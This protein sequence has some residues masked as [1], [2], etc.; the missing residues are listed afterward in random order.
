MILKIF[1]F[2]RLGLF[3]LTYLGSRI[4]HL[5]PNSGIGSISPFQQFDYWKSMAQWDGGHYWNIATSGYSS[6]EDFAFFPL[7]PTLI[8][9]LSPLFLANTLLTG[10]L[11]SNIAFFLF[12][13]FFHKLVSAKYGKKIAFDA[14]V[15]FIFFPTTFFTVSYYSES[16]FLLLITL[17]FMY[18]QRKKFILTAFV[19]SLASLTR[20][21]GIFLAIAFLASYIS[22]LKFKLS[23]VNVNLFWLI[24]SLSGFLLYS[25]YLKLN[26]DDP[27]I[28]I[29]AQSLWARYISD[30]FSAMFSYFWAIITGQ[31]RPF[32]DYLDFL[33]TIIFLALLVFNTS[34]I[35]T[36]LWIFSILPIAVG[37]STGT[38]T[39][40]PRY[41]LSSLGAFII[42]AI[43]LTGRPKFKLV[44]WTISLILQIFL[45]IRFINGFWVA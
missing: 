37:A 10:L 32:N 36:S 27:F 34:K 6:L 35:S 24:A 30:P 28:Y 22:R 3:F 14:T 4:F 25:L 11:I 9:T 16:L 2:W 26:F 31:A 42:I 18:W 21:A 13:Y 39:S 45:S 33:F 5:N 1:L 8:R 19:V 23:K 17:A 29:S 40:M 7:F 41:L 20:S 44:I 12:L 38:L 15:T 43:L